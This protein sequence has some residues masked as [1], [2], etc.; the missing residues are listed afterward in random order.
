MKRIS[1]T[2][3][4]AAGF[5]A[6]SPCW[7]MPNPFTP[8]PDVS[9]DRIHFSAALKEGDPTNILPRK[10]DIESVNRYCPEGLRRRRVRRR[11]FVNRLNHLTA[12]EKFFQQ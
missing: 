4:L 9:A 12:E 1:A 11:K 6:G 2:K 8:T 10:T 5:G 7:D 3:P